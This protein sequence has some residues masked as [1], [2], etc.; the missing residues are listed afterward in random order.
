M[1]GFVIHLAVAYEYLEKHKNEIV[2]KENFFE[3]VLAPDFYSNKMESHYG[4]Y[5]TTHI[6]LIKFFDIGD[7]DIN[8]DFGKGYLLH[9]I[10]DEAFYNNYFLEETIYARNNNMKYYNDY[11]CLNEDLIKIFNI[12]YIPEKAKECI[13]FKNEIPN[14]LE[15]DKVINFIKDISRISLKE[16]IESIKSNNTVLI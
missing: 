3:G 4:N 8:T 13:N 1:P 11:N 7:I 6:G 12:N 16:Q 14:I 10:T 9:L 2:N 15:L 5:S